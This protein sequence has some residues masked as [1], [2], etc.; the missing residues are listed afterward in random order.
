MAGT[1]DQVWQFMISYQQ[2][3]GMPPTMDEIRG[4]VPGLGYRSSA[5]YALRG[6]VEQGKVVEAADPGSSR[7]HRAIEDPEPETIQPRPERDMP[8]LLAVP[9]LFPLGG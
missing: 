6:L 8:A 2:Q 4:S 1:N 3:H 5:Q 7:R 9:A